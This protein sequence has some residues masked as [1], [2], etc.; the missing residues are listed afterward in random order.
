MYECKCECGKIIN[1]RATALRKGNQV[2]CGCVGKHYLSNTK[3]FITWQNMRKRCNKSYTTG[4]ENYGGRGIKV[5]DEWNDFVNFYNDMGKCPDG[6]SLD[7]IDNSKGYSKENCRW[8]SRIEQN[9]NK[10]NVSIIEFNGEKLDLKELSKRVGLSYNTLFFRHHVKK[11]LIE[12]IENKKYILN[13]EDGIFYDNFGIALK[14]YSLKRD[15]VR[16]TFEKNNKYNSLVL[17]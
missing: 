2:S 8:A 11:D 9:R 1:V 15:K 3:E 16:H 10:R 6:Y 7:R 17:V 12:Y 5:C 13:L 14:T 4:F